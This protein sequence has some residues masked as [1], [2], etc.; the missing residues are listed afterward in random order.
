MDK[1]GPWIIA[2]AAVLQFQR[3]LPNG[4][5]FDAGNVE[6]QRLTFNVKTMAGGATTSLHQHRIVFGRSIAGD[7]MNLAISTEG[8]LHQVDV[9]DKLGVHRGHLTSVMTSQDMVDVVER[10]EVVATLFVA[11]PDAQ[12]L[13]GM[14]IVKR[15]LSFG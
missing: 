3:R 13:T 6:I 12:P 10:G 14:N 4:T 15:E 7:D 2:D 8:F 9:L 11:K 5:M 1:S